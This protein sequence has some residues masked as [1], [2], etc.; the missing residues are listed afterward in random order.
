M[1]SL[2]QDIR[3]GM[4]MLAKNP[5]FTAVA[6]I[7]LAVAIGTNT[8]VFSVVDALFVRPLPVSG[9][10]ELIG[11]LGKGDGISIPYYSYYRDRA[12]SFAALA[13]HY[14]TAPIY[15][16]T[17]S[18]SQPVEGAAVSA[19]YFSILNLQP[20]L[21]RFFLPEEDSARGRN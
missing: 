5:G 18:G 20:A 13:A 11:I 17:D 15:L 9:A 4:R 3:Y 16:V 19:N 14:S 12:T 10:R 7:T 8:I 2:F 21:G 1:E 6:V